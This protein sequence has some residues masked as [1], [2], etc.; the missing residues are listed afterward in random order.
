MSFVLGHYT[1]PAVETAVSNVLGKK[2]SVLELPEGLNM[3]L[4]SS[5][6]DSAL[7]KS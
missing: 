7:S 1:M 6:S 4:S 5:S 2:S 3:F